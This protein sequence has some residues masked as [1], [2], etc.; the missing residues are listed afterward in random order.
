L[1]M[2]TYQLDTYNTRI[3]LGMR[4]KGR[5]LEWFHSRPEH[6]ELSVEEILA[7]KKKIFDYRQS[8]LKRRKQFEERM[9]K[10]GK[11]FSAY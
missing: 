9:W 6:L 4:L 8:K 11:S 5:A 10:T 3:L 7:K 2:L 1:L